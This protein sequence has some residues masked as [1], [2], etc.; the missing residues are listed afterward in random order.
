MSQFSEILGSTL[1]ENKSIRFAIVEN[2]YENLLLTLNS[3]SC[4]IDF[5]QNRAPWGGRIFYKV[6]YQKFDRPQFL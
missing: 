6:R 5:S 1:T 4:G 3:Q 2:L